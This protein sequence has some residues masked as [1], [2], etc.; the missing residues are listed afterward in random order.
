VN[1]NSRKG[2]QSNSRKVRKGNSFAF[3][4]AHP[5]V[6]AAASA[7]KTSGKQDFTAKL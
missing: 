5:R 2:Q 7:V 6:S 1:R 4:I 3:L